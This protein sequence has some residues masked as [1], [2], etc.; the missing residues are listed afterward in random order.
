MQGFPM[1][2]FRAFLLD[3]DGVIY[4]GEHRLP[5]ARELV[6]W[7]DA[8][9]RRVLYLSNNSMQTPDEVAE[10]L[11]RL[12]MP[13]PH[14][15]VLTAGYAAAQFIAARYP[16]RQVYVLALPSVERMVEEAGLRVVWR[17][18]VDGPTPD[19]VLVGLD[20]TLTYPRLKRALRALLEGAAFIA[21]NRDPRLPMEDSFEPGTGA[22]ATALEYASGVRAEIVGKPAP[23]I[24][25]EAMRQLDVRAEET[26]VVGDGLDLDVVA[27][28]AAGATTALVLTGLTTREQADAAEGERRPELLFADCHELLRA[29]Q[30]RLRRTPA[31][32]PMG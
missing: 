10:R 30:R 2:D 29:A 6:E 23:G 27:G 17:D 13:R 24:V 16:G 20:R 28:H 26:L 32:E 1:Q 21:V 22:I 15:R 9:E 5:G 14:G 11:A 3:L 25:L 7:L 31:P 4:R 19:V 12:G 8:S 18:E